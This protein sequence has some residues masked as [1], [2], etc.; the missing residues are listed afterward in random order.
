MNS[1]LLHGRSKPREQIRLERKTRM[2]SNRTLALF[3]RQEGNRNCWCAPF[4]VAK[5]CPE[6]CRDDPLD[7]IGVRLRRV[8]VLERGWS[9]HGDALCKALR[10]DSRCRIGW[11]SH[12]RS[13]SKI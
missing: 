8:A 12:R 9:T 3:G 1:R 2:E 7:R 13:N 6:C 11:A 10:Y 4:F 5:T